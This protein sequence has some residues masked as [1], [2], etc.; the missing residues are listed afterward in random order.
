MRS[1]FSSSYVS[2]PNSAMIAASSSICVSALA[3]FFSAT[4]FFRASTAS[5]SR[6]YA[7]SSSSACRGNAASCARF[8]HVTADTIKDILS[9]SLFNKQKNKK[10]FF[11]FGFLCVSKRLTSSW[12][13]FGMKKFVLEELQLRREFAARQDAFDEDETRRELE[14][15]LRHDDVVVTTNVCEQSCDEK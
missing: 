6:M 9:Q 1:S 7:S 8:T 13:V 10:K 15:A 2:S 5:A 12:G 11:F 14:R 3:A 4:A